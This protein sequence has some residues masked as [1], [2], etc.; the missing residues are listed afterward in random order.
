MPSRRMRT[1]DV[2]NRQS[3]LRS[4]NGDER[5]QVLA[6]VA[7]GMIGIIA[8]V[9]LVIDGG[10]AWAQQRETQNGADA[11]A[12]AGATVIQQ[13]IAGTPRT[14]GDVGCAVEQAADANGVELDA[15]VYTDAFGAALVPEIAVGACVPSPAASLPIPGAAQGVRDV[16]SQQ[17]DTFLMQV[18]GFS[19]MTAT[20]NAAAVVGRYAGATGS[21]LPVT[22]PLSFSTCDSSL[23][24]Y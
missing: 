19:E 6:I 4:H 20:A 16:G 11:V 1:E 2:M 7:M 13:S 9:G 23:T 21:I 14:D 3:M 15:V 24:T 5:G 12:F 8:M 22:I 17:F 10:F 18:V